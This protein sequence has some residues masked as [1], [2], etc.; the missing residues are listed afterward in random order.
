MN[1]KTGC[2]VFFVLVCLAMAF[3][4][5]ERVN[6]QA[7]ATLPT[8]APEPAELEFADILEQ[9]FGYVPHSGAY[10]ATVGTIFSDVDVFMSALDFNTVKMQKWFSYAGV[11]EN[12]ISMGY[13]AKLGSIYLGISYGGSLIDEVLRRITNQEVLTLRKRDEMEKNSSGDNPAKSEL[14]DS[15]GGSIKGTAASENTIGIVFGSGGF[16]L[17]L[18]FAAFMQSRKLGSEEG[19]NHEQD[20]EH[21]F[22]SSLKP[23]LELGFNFPVGSARAKIALR[24]AYDMHQYFSETGETF[25]YTK[26]DNDGVI[27]LQSSFVRKV[28]YQDFTEPSGG[29]TLGF[30]FG[31]GKNV[32]TEFDLVGDVVYRTY[33]NNEQDGILT[34]WGIADEDTDVVAPEILDLR[35][36]GYPV[37]TLQS[38]VSKRLTV[39]AKLRLAIEHNIFTISQLLYNF[40]PGDPEDP[41]SEKI[42]A[43][44]PYSTVKID[45]SY[46]SIIP[47]LGIGTKFMLWPD[48]FSLHSGFGIDLF[49]YTETILTRTATEDSVDNEST[50]TVKELGLPTTK[51]TAGLTL[52]FTTDMALDLLAIT[53]G[54]DINA[55]KLTILLTINK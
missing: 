7:V 52:N 55:T 14:Y 22:E 5:P 39:G 45:Y 30:G 48:H 17:K 46:L 38:D 11:D 33:Q 6:A 1:K 27:T 12:G 31:E 36:S 40:E 54:L 29:F 37:F 41:G 28:V 51:I 23:S 24:G 13:A 20:Y 8:K 18:G 10:K 42:R 49:S 9:K 21:A 47:E 53:S 32:R 4:M 19:W 25:Y 15:E 26:T 44:D 35:I 50:K 3:F 43:P 2:G 34:M 16:G